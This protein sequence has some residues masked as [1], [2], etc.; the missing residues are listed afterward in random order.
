MAFF[1]F[2]FTGSLQSTGCLLCQSL[3]CIHILNEK[4]KKD[5]L[6]SVKCIQQGKKH[7]KC[8]PIHQ[9]DNRLHAGKL[10]EKMK[11]A[12]IHTS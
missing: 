11:N 9:V 12:N 6:S 3:K 4:K 1:I 8:E 10:K 5:L 2:I 7:L